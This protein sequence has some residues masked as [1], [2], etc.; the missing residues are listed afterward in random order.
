MMNNACH[1]MS[2][3]EILNSKHGEYKL[4]NAT[5]YGNKV[6]TAKLSKRVSCSIKTLPIRIKFNYEYD[7]VKALKAGVT[8]DPSLTL[9]GKIFI[10]GLA[11][12]EDIKDSF[13]LLTK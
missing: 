6:D 10:E 11:Q 7:T 13:K 12:A 3:G 1:I 9:D 5:L 2:D 4:Y 8:K